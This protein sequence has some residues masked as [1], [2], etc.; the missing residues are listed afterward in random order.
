MFAVIRV[1][2]ILCGSRLVRGSGLSCGGSPPLLTST[3]GGTSFHP[4]SDILPPPGIGLD[5]K[6][7]YEN[8]FHPITIEILTVVGWG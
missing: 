6:W 8:P 3:D 5:D 1:E 2:G 4:F 7:Y